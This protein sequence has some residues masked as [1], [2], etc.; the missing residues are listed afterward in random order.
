MGYYILEESN[1][2]AESRMVA[3]RSWRNA[4]MGNC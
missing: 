3:A 1:S 2:K 4:E